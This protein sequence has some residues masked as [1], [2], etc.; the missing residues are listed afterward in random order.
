MYRRLFPVVIELAVDPEPVTRTLFSS[1]AYQLARWFTRNQAREAAETVALLDAITEGLAGGPT[2]DADNAA[3][4]ASGPTAQRR[5]LC[6][7]LAAECLRWSVKHLPAAAAAGGGSGSSGG[8]GG[9][10][11]VN[12]KSILR[13]LFAFQTHPTPGKRLGAC[14]ALQRCLAELRQYP[15]LV[16]AHALEILETALRSLRLCENDPPRAGAE[17]AGALLCRAAVRACARHAGALSRAPTAQ[18]SAQRGG[19]FETLPRLV[20]WIFARGTARTETRAR[21]ESQLAFAALVQR[22][23]GYVSPARWLDGVRHT[24]GGAA[25]P[26]RVTV[27]Q[28][29]REAMLGTKTE[30]VAGATAWMRNVTASLHWARWALERE[31]VDLG[32]IVRGGAGGEEEGEGGNEFTAKKKLSMPPTHPS[33]RRLTFCVGASRSSRET[34]RT[35]RSFGPRRPLAARGSGTSIA[36]GSGSRCR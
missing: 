19:A 20:E 13:R 17:E 2:S 21:L 30:D 8:G 24:M 22:L 6:A 7:K 26:F 3:E 33:R 23:P 31:V 16:E 28:P 35:R 11:A 9:G 4:R 14:V 36:R 15:Q 29:E 18:S 12:V 25:W 10:A 5:E 34:G 27:P 32:I 1:L